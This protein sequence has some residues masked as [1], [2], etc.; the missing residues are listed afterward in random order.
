MTTMRRAAFAASAAAL[1]PFLSARADVVDLSGGESRRSRRIPAF[2]LRAEA[3]TEFAPY[4]TVGAALSYFLPNAIG[5]F[6]IEAGA[7]AGFPGVQL[8]L[9]ARQLVGEAGDYFA[10]ELSIAGNTKKK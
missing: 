7:G 6:E 9:A 8:G 4:G 1:L 5:G 10:F 2:A 3:G